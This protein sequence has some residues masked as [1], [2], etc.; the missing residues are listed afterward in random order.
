MM[1]LRRFP[2]S[3]RE[4]GEKFNVWVAWLNLE[5][6]YGEPAEEAVMGLFRRALAANPQKALY[7]AL[8][9]ILERSQKVLPSPGQAKYPMTPVVPV[10][11]HSCPSPLGH[12]I[13]EHIMFCMGFCLPQKYGIC[14]VAKKK[15]DLRHPFCRCGMTRSQQGVT[16]T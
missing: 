12:I 7:M 5:N 1:M 11:A 3:C 2:D 8:I 4:E 6:L 15:S 13:L 14:H 9:N 16:R 10:C